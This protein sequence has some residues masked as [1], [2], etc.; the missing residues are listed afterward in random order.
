MHG[1]ASGVPAATACRP[2]ASALESFVTALERFGRATR[3]A[4]GRAN[5]SSSALSHAQYL[6]IEALL[7]EPSMNVC[8]LAAAAEVAQP[9]ATRML[10]GLERDGIL[11]RRAAAG[12]RRV[13]LIE[14]T[15]EGRAVLQERRAEMAAIRERIFLSIPEAQRAQAAELLEHLAAAVEQL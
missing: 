7:D 3:R 14:L 13:A 15:P 8:R 10:A 12:D 5:Q 11:R 1:Y 2:P 9:T 6:L 4:R